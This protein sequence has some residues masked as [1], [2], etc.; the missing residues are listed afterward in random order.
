MKTILML[1]LLLVGCAQ[2]GVGASIDQLRW[3]AGSWAAEG[4]DRSTEELWTEPAGGL[5]LGLNR[6]V[7]VRG[8]T[9]F[10]FLRIE[11]RDREVVYLASPG[12][13]AP[14]PFTLVKV[15]AARAEFENAQ[16]DFPQRVIYWKEGVNLCARVETLAGEGEQWCWE[17]KAR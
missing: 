3:M 9:Q 1:L 10:E 11:Q 7:P 5:M 15:T 8:K 2:V 13:A 16:H 17:P 12:G 4:D 6:S 14:T